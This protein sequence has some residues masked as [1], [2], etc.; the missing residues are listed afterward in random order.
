[1][2]QIPTPLYLAAPYS[3]QPGSNEYHNVIHALC[4][5]RA[6]GE[7]GYF[8]IS[9]HASSWSADPEGEWFSEEWWYDYTMRQ[10]RL[11]D[12]VVLAPERPGVERLSYGV[13]AELAE[14]KRLKMPIYE[15]DY[16]LRGGEL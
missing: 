1:M 4:T 15:A 11:C 7:L 12:A 5:W 9:P 13:H 16:I 3:G 6:L 10:M 8:V 2:I 14:A